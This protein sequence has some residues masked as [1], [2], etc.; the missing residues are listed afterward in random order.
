V[1]PATIQLFRD[2]ALVSLARFGMWMLVPVLACWAL[3]TVFRRLRGD[4]GREPAGA[5]GAV[6]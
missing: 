6:P 2:G 1:L 4:S 5:R 3:A